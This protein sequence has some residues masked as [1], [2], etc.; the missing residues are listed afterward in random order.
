MLVGAIP[1]I[2]F[3]VIAFS[4]PVPRANLQAENYLRGAVH[5]LERAQETLESGQFELASAHATL[6]L[7]DQG[8]RVH[9]DFS[10]ATGIQQSEAK[11]AVETSIRYWNSTLGFSSLTQVEDPA[12]ADVR[13]VFQREVVLRGVQ[14]GGYCSQSRSVSYDTAGNAASQYSA[15]IFARLALPGGK[16]LDENCLTNI[17]AHEF[18]HVYGLSDNAKGG[19]LMSPLSPSS[20]RFDLEP[21]ELEALR[22]LRLTAFEIRH[23][24]MARAKAN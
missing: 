2:V 22:A 4:S 7:H 19:H 24:V 15:T 18:G 20:P 3:A 8:L 5:H 14:V 23:A 16:A 13:V 9:V 11:A 1:K 6:V 10:Q 12:Q 17:V 21:D